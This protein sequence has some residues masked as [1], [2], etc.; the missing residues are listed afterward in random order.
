METFRKKLELKWL[1]YKRFELMHEN[2]NGLKL[3]FYQVNEKHA[4]SMAGVV[5]TALYT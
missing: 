1:D 5:H 3:F 4:N 2:K